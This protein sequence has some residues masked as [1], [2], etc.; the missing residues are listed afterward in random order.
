MLRL[1][2]VVFVAVALGAGCTSDAGGAAPPG[3]AEVVRVVDGDTIVVRI[4]GADE[5]VRLIG[6]DTPESV[7]PDT[8]VECFGRE[9]AGHTKRL[10]PKGAKV[11][12]IRDV[13]AR[14]RYGRLLAYVYRQHDGLF[15]NLELAEAG[16]ATTLTYPPNVAHAG[17]FVA[18]SRRARDAGRGLWQRCSLPSPA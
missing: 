17:D 9:A 11:R 18:A 7:R 1:V 12:L 10:L 14:D 4:A 13:E 2:I 3:Q 8:P 15:V 16:F 6:V 5:S